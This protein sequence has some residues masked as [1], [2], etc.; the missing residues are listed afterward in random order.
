[1]QKRILGLA[2][3]ALLAG[4][5]ITTA[6][7]AKEVVIGVLYPLTGPVAQVGKDAVAAVKTAIQI[8]N[9][10]YDLDMPLAK[11]K[12][13]SGLGGAKISMIVGDHG[14]KPDVGQGETERMINQEKV[15]AMFG[16]YYSS[17]TGAS[18]LVA[19]R[20]GIPWVNG[21]ST[22][23]KL[24]TRGL[25]YFFRVTPHDGEFTALMFEFAKDFKKKTGNKLVN[26]A[27]FHEDS[28]WGSDSGSV[29]DKMAKAQGYKVVEKIAYKA[30]TTSLTAEVQRLKAANADMFLPS[31]YTSDAVLF[32]KTAKELDYNPKLLVA[33]NAGYTDPS[34]LKTMG[35]DAEGV[36]TRSPF[37]TDLADM[38]PLIGKINELFKK[39]S[40]GRDLS[41]VPARAFTGFIALADAINRA[42]STDPEKIR[43]SLTETNIPGSQLIVPYRGIKFGKDGQN[44]LTRGILM[45]V[46]NG[47]Y[48]T[49]YPFELAACKLVYPMPTW[50]EKAKR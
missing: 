3:T 6:A 10:S 7:Q 34:F 40:G 41:D 36:I 14:G 46:Q 25:K 32:M 12:G 42:G 37:N 45:Q 38:I 19:E 13:L 18:S 24:T 9:G 44:M 35:N 49:I 22:S 33:Q 15:V 50:A 16:A 29:Q 2:A 17:V 48:C 1:M 23:P 30:K 21:E 31:S 47:K 5:A 27:I 11:N 39:N 43:Q 28:L 4:V 26:V 20:A 8:I